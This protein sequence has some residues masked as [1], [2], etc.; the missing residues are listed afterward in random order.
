MG[1]A[2]FNP[3]VVVPVRATTL[4]PFLY[5]SLTVQGGVATLSEVIGDRAFAFAL[6][7]VLGWLQARGAMWEV[8][9]YRTDLAAMPFRT[10]AL[11][12]VEG[13][14]LLP[15][16]ARR[17]ALDAE[18]GIQD[19]IHKASAKGNFKDFWLIQEA[20]HEAVY[21]GA[22]FGFD[23]FAALGTDTLVLRIGN[24]RAGALALERD[25]APGTVRLNVATAALFG[26]GHLSVERCLLHDI[27]LSK[28]MTLEKAAEEAALW[29]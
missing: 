24:N 8:M 14:R 16:T 21:R 4:T 2:S 1:T 25:P 20:A 13:A 3:A 19:H 11:T 28:A 17:C 29:H 12:A 7:S 23:P 15:P 5:G 6:C 10:S 18:A 26:R 27:Q 22:V 9:D